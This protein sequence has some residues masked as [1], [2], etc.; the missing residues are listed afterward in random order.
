MVFHRNGNKKGHALE[1]A[2]PSGVAFLC[3]FDLLSEQRMWF[4]VGSDR[5]LQSRKV[6]S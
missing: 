2:Q 5:H 1:R 6:R 4:E 3:S